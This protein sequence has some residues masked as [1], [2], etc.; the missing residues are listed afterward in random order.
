[1][2]GSSFK[3]IKKK[4][5]KKNNRNRLPVV[6]C[7]RLTLKKWFLANLFNL[8]PL[9]FCFALLSPS[10]P[11]LLKRVFFLLFSSILFIFLWCD[12]HSRE[13]F[14]KNQQMY[15]NNKQTKKNSGKYWKENLMSREE[16][17]FFLRVWNKF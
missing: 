2:S 7:L 5:V 15:N 8:L 17:V 14:N 13:T 1:M 4:K 6:S 11:P 12:L 3:R 10:S 9:F 16:V